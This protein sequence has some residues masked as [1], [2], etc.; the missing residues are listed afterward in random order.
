MY[1]A[2]VVKMCNFRRHLRRLG[3]VRVVDFL[4]SRRPE[5]EVRRERFQPPNGLGRNGGQ[6][7]RDQHEQERL[8][9]VQFDG[10]RQL[11]DRKPGIR[12]RVP[13]VSQARVMLVHIKVRPVEP[14][15][16]REAFVPVIKPLHGQ[17][18]AVLL[19][20]APPL[21]IVTHVREHGRAV[22]RERDHALRPRERR[23]KPRPQDRPPIRLEQGQGR[24]GN[25]VALHRDL[26]PSHYMDTPAAPCSV[27]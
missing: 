6:L 4:F 24:E 11:A 7:V 12:Q 22:P 1:D 8:G 9:Q 23:A 21:N 19:A 5:V 3:S 18:Q 27:L 13:A 2:C 26:S 25:F 16:A 14:H 15:A 20:A 10:T 17:A